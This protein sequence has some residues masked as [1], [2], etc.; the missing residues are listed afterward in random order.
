M[1]IYVGAD[2]NGFYL[3][4]SLLAYL[5]RAGY[6]VVDDGDQRLEPTDDYPI[7]AG[8]VV[9]DMQSSNDPDAR[10]V[11]ICGSGQGMCIAANRFKGIRACL[12]Y[13]QESVKAARNDDDSNVL[14]LP[15]KYLKEGTSEIIVETWLN[16]PFA[17]AP[18]YIR[19]KQEL[20][21]L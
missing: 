16:T 14:C 19:R 5:K 2:H 11:L 17:A 12:G 8:R 6:D 10:G 1:K 15:A 4:A 13:D 21:N 7:F 18:R 20:D 3:K 9:A